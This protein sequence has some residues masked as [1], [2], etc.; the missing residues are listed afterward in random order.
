MTVIAALAARHSLTMGGLLRRLN[1]RR[2]AGAAGPAPA[3]GPSGRARGLAASLALT[4]A[5][6]LGLIASGPFSSAEAQTSG[7]EK[8]VLRIEAT[9]HSSH[10]RSIDMNA[11]ETLLVT[12]AYDRT[13]RVWSI[14][15]KDGETFRLQRILRPPIGANDEGKVYTVAMS[16][17]GKLV[18]AA[19]W[20][21]E[22][23]DPDGD[24]AVYVF[25]WQTGQMVQ[26]IRN[27]PNVVNSL[28]FSA[29]GK[30]LVTAFAL[31]NDGLIFDTT[32]WAQHARLPGIGDNVYGLAFN[33]VNGSLAVTSYDGLVRL[34]GPDFR[35]LA[36]VPS[37]DG[38]RPYKADFSPDGKTLAVGHT[39]TLRVTLFKADDLTYIRTLKDDKIRYGD[40]LAVAW[41]KDGRTIY[42]GGRGETYAPYAAGNGV[43]QFDA[44]S[45]ALLGILTAAQNTIMEIAQMDDGRIMFGA[46]DPTFGFIDPAFKTV[47]TV[48]VRVLDYRTYP[49]MKEEN[50]ASLRLAPDGL[51]VSL[52][53]E[54]FTDK[55]Y[56]TFDI[57]ERRVKLSET[58]NTALVKPSVT[59][60]GLTFANWSSSEAPI[61][62]GAPIAIDRYEISRALAISG[63][64][65]SFVLGADWY[66]RRYDVRSDGTTTEVWRRPVPSTA[67][68]VNIT[69]DGRFAVAAYGD[70]TVR[71]HSME[72]GEE[73][74]AL[75]L[76]NE[77]PRPGWVM[78]TPQG[79]Y[80]ASPG[81]E[82][83]IGWHVNK[84]GMKESLF[85]GASR[86]RDQFYRPDV[87]DGVLDL[88]DV[89]A[90]VREANLRTG[91]TVTADRLIDI[92]PPVVRILKS[93]ESTTFAG[94]KTKILYLLE[95]PSGKPVTG[96]SIR[97]D[98]QPLTS[99]TSGLNIGRVNQIEL[100]NIPSRD[101][102]LSLIAQTSD[103]A[104]EP[105]LL[106]LTYTGDEQVG[107]QKPSLYGLIVGVSDYDV[108]RL[109]LGYAAQD[110]KDF[111]SVLQA[112]SGGLYG[113]VEIRLLTDKEASRSAILEGL[114]WLSSVTTKDDVAVLFMAGHGVTEA[115]S[116]YYFLPA[117]A[118]PERLRETGVTR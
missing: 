65:K 27:L 25:D 96:L 37:P 78:W 60:P 55:N 95:S 44:G 112:Q 33:E 8:P 7:D 34:Y 90:A 40:L 63:N 76:T 113:D 35:F 100:E 84:G 118:D 87:I 16:P 79:Y 72:T 54:A 80:D 71:W 74:L 5:L 26:A 47:T 115:S 98:G 101:V 116:R 18:A 94:G 30:Y 91:P 48:P 39:D 22:A 107:D 43:W 50:I 102:T 11:D 85:F 57:R 38:Q 82:D 41:S 4:L 3:M 14:P 29:D 31:E 86:F 110:A 93:A 62:N 10:L 32:S 61:L 117:E 53:I 92:A 24:F 36:Q 12:G 52:P 49:Y 89:D 66:I 108:E 97:A 1:P 6:A 59:A 83:L 103:G 19:G 81:A 45:G 15:Q 111:A 13:V 106:Q 109:K 68:R 2:D 20:T 21:G 67:W 42:A 70:G 64:A 75:F 23:F 69:N 56:F 17:D 58:E 105:D 104:G 114:T 9:Q 88:G 77:F 73:L 28:K 99:V 46:Q 51:S